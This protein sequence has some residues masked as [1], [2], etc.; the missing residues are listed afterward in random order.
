MAAHSDGVGVG[1]ARG[2]GKRLFTSF[3]R[4]ITER[5]GGEQRLHE[6]QPNCCMSRE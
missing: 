6:L 5:Q 1:E 3:V 2:G 4:D